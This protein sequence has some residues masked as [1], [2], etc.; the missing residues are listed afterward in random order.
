[1]TTPIKSNTQV[2]TGVTLDAISGGNINATKINGVTIPSANAGVAGKVPT[3]QGDGTAAWITLPTIP[4]PPTTLPSLIVTGALTAGTLTVSGLITAANINGV[5]TVD[6]V[7]YTTIAG[8]IASLP[9]TGSFII[10]LP[11]G[12]RETFTSHINLGNGTNQSVFL[13]MDSDVIVTCNVT[14]GSYGFTVHD[15]GGIIGIRNQALTVGRGCGSV[16]SLA[17]TCNV[18]NVIQTGESPQTALTFL[19]FEI[20]N[21]L[22]GAVSN[23]F[24]NIVNLNNAH[25]IRDISG[26]YFPNVGIRISATT[27]GIKSTGPLNVDNCFFDGVGLSGA[28]PLIIE[29]DGAGA[30]NVVRVSGGLFLN[31]GSGKA[32]IEINGGGSTT[33]AMRD[34]LISEVYT[35]QW[36][37]T[38][39]VIGIKIID[40]VGVIIQGGEFQLT[41]A[42]TGHTGI[43]IDQGG[44]GRTHSIVVE[45]FRF[46]GGGGNAGLHNVI[47]GK[48]VL[49]STGNIPLYIYQGTTGTALPSPVILDSDTAIELGGNV[50]FYGH[51]AAS[52]PTVTGSRGSNAALTS[53]LTA[54][55]SLG[56]LTDSST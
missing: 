14:D 2:Q 37:G 46:G 55:T 34:V 45:N 9:S 40:A 31:P 25:T 42:T 22:G 5:R 13:W 20:D 53:L 4:G 33:G 30:N 26:F 7:T 52:K 50:G 54:L 44:S 41:D 16:I 24:F 51:A 28:R 29:S 43:S 48:T 35:Q 12:Y 47:T 39:T 3:T 38:T 27:G 49:T 21:V 23:A 15:G 56:L 17:A 1:M 10:H 8:A 11:S 18:T 19:G 32:C 6:G 36:A